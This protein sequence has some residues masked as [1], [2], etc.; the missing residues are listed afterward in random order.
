VRIGAQGHHV[1]FVPTSHRS[2]AQRL[3]SSARRYVHEAAGNRQPAQQ[4][5]CAV[6]NPERRNKLLAQGVAV[7]N[8]TLEALAVFLKC[9]IEKWRRVSLEAGIKPE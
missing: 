5:S 6:E 2:H 1:L 3:L 7:V 9:E 4:R 8:S